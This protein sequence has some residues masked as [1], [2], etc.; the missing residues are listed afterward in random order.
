ML[1]PD[2]SYDMGIFRIYNILQ[3]PIIKWRM[4]KDDMY[5]YMHAYMH[6]HKCV[7]MYAHMDI[8]RRK[9][10]GNLST[11]GKRIETM[12]HIQTERERVQKTPKVVTYKPALSHC[13]ISAR[14]QG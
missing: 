13:P 6:V 10:K 11:G 14:G 8:C 12:T 7:H 4:Q 9:R 5:L 3:A 2:T 1:S